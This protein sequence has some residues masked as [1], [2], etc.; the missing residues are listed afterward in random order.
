MCEKQ[1]RN[2]GFG[3]GKMDGFS[4]T[5]V[6][7]PMWPPSG[8]VTFRTYRG[9]RKNAALS[10]KIS[11]LGPNQAYV[12]SLRQLGTAKILR[13]AIVTSTGLLNYPNRRNHGGATVLRVW[14]K[15]MLRA[16]RT[17]I[18]FG[19]YPICNIMA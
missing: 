17:K 11:L 3:F 15:I 1:T 9:E 16:E 5:R 6:S 10:W 18:F 2:P 13:V 12:A 7:I 4:K 14:Y 19:L 8:V